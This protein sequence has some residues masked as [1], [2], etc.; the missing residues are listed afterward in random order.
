MESLAILVTIIVLA[1]YGSGVAAFTA[2]WFKGSKARFVTNFF[3]AISIVSGGWLWISLSDGNGF[4]V[5]LFPI[6]L[7]VFAILNHRR[8]ING[9]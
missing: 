1:I 3:A 4:F 8:R 5:G 6:S 2:S 9:T 7:G